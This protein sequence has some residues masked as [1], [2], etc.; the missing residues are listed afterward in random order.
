MEVMSKLHGFEFADDE[1]PDTT[2]RLYSRAADEWLAVATPHLASQ[3]KWD[4]S[5][6][7]IKES[8]ELAALDSN[9]Q[10]LARLDIHLTSKLHNEALTFSTI[11]GR[12]LSQSILFSMEMD[13]SKSTS[14]L[15][16]EV[17][18][19]PSVT[20]RE[21]LPAVE[22]LDNLQPGN[23]I[24]LRIPRTRKMLSITDVPESDDDSYFKRI[25]KHYSLL[26]ASP[27]ARQARV[28]NAR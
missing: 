18:L 6:A 17:R 23:R 24:G 25:G 4:I 15:H 3:G 28:P 10:V 13:I 20:P 12:D 19:N 9:D 26:G 1:N 11:S 22:F 27:E 8:L 7:T 21:L 5:A 14:Q 2:G 16:M